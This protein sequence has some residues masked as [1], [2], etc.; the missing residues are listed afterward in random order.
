MTVR[1][2]LVAAIL[3]QIADIGRQMAG[4]R[5]RPFGEHRLSRNQV[6]ALFVL[7]HSPGP[8][9]SGALADALTVT[10]GAVTQLVG[11]LREQQLVETAP[12]AADG[13]V[14]VIRLT[15][16]AR[17]QVD[18]FERAAVE[19]LAPVFDGLDD[20]ELA[21]LAALLSKGDGHVRRRPPAG[22]AG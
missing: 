7:A 3:Q 12:D 22:G 10:P 19:R 2:E 17:A 13:R 9:T 11:G 1:A 8:V 6:E 20:R 15:D 16:H 21:Q 18:V 4:E 14:R 5:S